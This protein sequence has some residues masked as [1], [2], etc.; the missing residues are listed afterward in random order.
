MHKPEIR[1]SQM[2]HSFGPG[3][4]VDLPDDSIIVAGLEEWRY[5]EHANQCRITEPRL[6]EKVIDSLSRADIKHSSSLFLQSP[7]PKSERDNG[8]QSG[9]TGWIFPQWFVV[10]HVVYRGERRSRPLVHRSM[11]D[12]QKRCRIDGKM[13]SSV[14]IRVVAA[15]R[16]GHI[17]D[18][19]WKGFVHRSPGCAAGELWIEEEGSSGDI[20]RIHI[21]CTCGAE[22]GLGDAAV[23]NP[24]SPPLG[25]CN[26]MRPWLGHFTEENCSQPLSLLTRSASNAYFPL[27]QSVISIPISEDPIMS[28]VRKHWDKLQVVP[29]IAVLTSFLQILELKIDFEGIAPEKIMQVI[30]DARSGKEGPRLT[31]KAAEFQAFT[32][33]QVEKSADKPDGDFYA[34]KLPRELWSSPVLLSVQD[35]VLVHR[36]REV[37]AQFGFTRLDPISPKSDG[38]SSVGNLKP[39]SLARE[40]NWVPAVENRGEGIFIQF[41]A[42]VIKKWL[43]KSAVKEREQVLSQG[44]K[45]WKDDRPQ[46]DREFEGAAYYMLH[47]LSHMLITSLALD[48]GYPMSSLRERIY[49]GVGMEGMYGILIYTG[50]SDAEGTLGGLIE[51]GRKIDRH[52]IRSLQAGKLCSNDPVCSTHDP[53]SEGGQNLLGSACHGCQLIA[54]TSCEQFNNLLDRTLVVPTL[55]SSTE[56]AFFADII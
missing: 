34:R 53:R 28:L 38:E 12:E 29:D 5:G 21:R 16:R 35:I 51:A 24:N 50:S 10:N 43:E 30:N 9:V 8:P 11:L 25:K 14:P 52:F 46:L 55:N 47:S 42:D 44:F 23:S 41:K 20:S 17:T 54:E 33:A 18:L 49:G 31:V 39:A 19:D 7:P 22:R 2:V 27:I 32:G 45:R 3:S 13:C 6:L 26:G 40:L 15:C 36:L 1:L 48:C 56:S 4:L 37:V